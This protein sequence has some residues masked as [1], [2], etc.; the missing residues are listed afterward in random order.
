MNWRERAVQ[1]DIR[2]G[3]PVSMNFPSY[4]SPHQ[5][6]TDIQAIRHQVGSEVWA[7]LDFLGEVFEIEDQRN[8]TDGSYKTYCPPLAVPY[9]REVTPDVEVDQ[10][11]RLSLGGYVGPYVVQ[12][13]ESQ[14]SLTLSQE[15]DGAIPRIGLGYAAEYGP[16]SKRQL[17]HLKQLNLSHIRVDLK[18]SQPDYRIHLENAWS[19]A[20][21]LGAGLEIALVLSGN[22]E[23]EI[24]DLLDELRS[25]KSEGF[26]LVDLRFG[27]ALQL[28]LILSDRAQTS[29]S[30][31]QECGNWRRY[32]C[33]LRGGEPIKTASRSIWIFCATR[34]ILRCMGATIPLWSRRSRPRLQQ[35]PV[36]SSGR[37]GAPFP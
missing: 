8:W 2:M 26:Q 20:E 34:S 36:Q 18:L 3:R 23:K 12:G 29:P 4:I 5:P 13:V 25:D 16:L 27:D 35:L 9:P 7:S 32:E 31:R 30:L 33:Q 28:R 15:T 37:K 24:E 22:P 1:F 10:T 19:D 17:D 6:F 21:A 11:V 14:V